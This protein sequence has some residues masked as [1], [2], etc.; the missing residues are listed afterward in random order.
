[1]KKKNILI[2]YLFL[3]GVLITGLNINLKAEEINNGGE[4]SSY[5]TQS[6]TAN[7][8]AGKFDLPDDIVE[9]FIM[10]AV[11]Y[12]G[13]LGTM[14]ETELSSLGSAFE[15]DVPK[16]AKTLEGLDYYISKGYFPYVE[17]VTIASPVERLDVLETLP[18]TTFWIV[19][20]IGGIA[21]FPDMSNWTKLE[22]F[23]ITDNSDSTPIDLNLLN[24][25][26]M[27]SLKSFDID[28]SPNVINLGALGKAPALESLNIY[29]VPLVDSNAINSIGNISTLE[30]LGIEGAGITNISGI[31]NLTNL[32]ALD[33]SYNQISDI[34]GLSNLTNLK[35]VYLNDNQISDI[36]ALENLTNLIELNLSNNQVSDIS[37]V[38]NLNNLLYIY[39]SYNKISD[40]RPL[41]TQYANGVNIY[42]DNQSIDLN[43]GDF[44][45]IS[46]IPT[47]GTLYWADGTEVKID[48]GF[49]PADITDFKE[50]NYGTFTFDSGLTQYGRPLFFGDVTIRLSYVAPIP[51]TPIGPS[52]P[53]DTDGD[54]L[55]DEDENTIGTDINNPDTDGDGIDDKTEVD[56]GTDPLTPETTPVDPTKP[57]NDSKKEVEKVKQDANK[58]EEEKKLI[59]TGSN[60]SIVVIIS[61]ILFLISLKALILTKKI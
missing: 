58:K 47:E 19:D 61:I 18:I 11:G 38:E 43:L 33:L 4:T 49:D 52:T 16:G 1:M 5:K 35:F 36:S 28:S 14:D 30:E 2:S 13:A 48:Y 24:I 15:F 6:I 57:V 42:G 59:Q 7:R 53:I 34:S 21:Q 29:D 25:G 51:L 32:T 9:Q 31:S 41:E 23:K 20:D 56:N 37:A 50:Y 12:T 26:T 17:I 44:E 8:A 22:E 3:V 39:L 27:K 46:E 45:D 40:F 60:L 10:D 55:S 54:G